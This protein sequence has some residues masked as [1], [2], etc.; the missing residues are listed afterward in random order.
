MGELAGGSPASSPEACSAAAETQRSRLNKEEGKNLFLKII[1]CDPLWH[2][3][4]HTHKHTRTCMHSR[5]N[6]S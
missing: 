2:V 3:C 6:T 1:L 5:Y 4:T